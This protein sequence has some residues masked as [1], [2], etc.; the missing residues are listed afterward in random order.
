[1]AA[2]R[3][4]WGRRHSILV[5]DAL[6]WAL[7]RNGRAAAALRYERAAASLGMQNALFFFHA[8]MIE[9]ALGDRSAALKDLTTALRINPNFSILHAAEA[10][11]ALRRLR[12]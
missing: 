9:R 3:A 12:A 8:G 11:R 1:M 10:R 5:A 2:A 7:Y 6:A 4:E